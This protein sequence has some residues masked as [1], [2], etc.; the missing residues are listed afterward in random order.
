MQ[1]LFIKFE[2]MITS[3]MDEQRDEARTRNFFYSLPTLKSFPSVMSFL[4]SRPIL[5]FSL[6]ASN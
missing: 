4:F 1:M 5:P 2:F 6:V 3:T